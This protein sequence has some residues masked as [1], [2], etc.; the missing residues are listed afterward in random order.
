MV[1]VCTIDRKSFL[2]L[3][4]NAQKSTTCLPYVLV[5]FMLSPA[6]IKTAVAFR[7][8]IMDGGI[9]TTDIIDRSNHSVF[10]NL[11]R[12]ISKSEIKRV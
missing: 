6:L 2:S 11:L 12:A 4:L 10:C 9:L 1:R 5:I 3:G 8:G 7:A